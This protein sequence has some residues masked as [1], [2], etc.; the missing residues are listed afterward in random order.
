MEIVQV[1]KNLKTAGNL[2]S[3]IKYAMSTNLFTYMLLL[4][5]PLTATAVKKKF[6]QIDQM[7]DVDLKKV[8]IN[9]GVL[10]LSILAGAIDTYLKTRFNSWK[11]GI[12]NTVV[13]AAL[14]YSSW[15]IAIKI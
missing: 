6:K 9:S 11:I 5:F 2:S 3:D 1:W 12:L 15:L 10:A 8:K 13:L 14:M 7:G 4:T